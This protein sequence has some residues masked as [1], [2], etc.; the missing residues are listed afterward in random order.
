MKFEVRGGP[1]AGMG[2]ELESEALIIGR[3]PGVQLELQD[4][5][6]S[7]RHAAITRAQDGTVKVE[8][9]ASRNGTKVDGKRISEPTELTGGETIK[10]GQTEIA[11]SA[12]AP[13][14]GATKVAGTPI[15]AG[16]EPDKAEA[17][18]AADGAGAPT[19]AVGAPPPA[20]APTS[21]APAPTEPLPPTKS[22]PPTPPP[23]GAKPPPPPPPPPPPAGKRP[24]GQSRISSLTNRLRPGS[25]R[26]ESAIQ[27]ILLQRSV[28]RA[29]I[30][31]IVAGGVALIAIIGLVL[32]FATDIFDDEPAGEGAQ[33]GIPDE[34]TASDIIEAARP[35]TVAILADVD[36]TNNGGGTGWVLDEEEGLI[37]TN[38]HVIENGETFR[39]MTAE[40]DI[41]PAEVVGVAICD[42]LAVVQVEDTEGMVVLPIGS[43]D[44]LEQGDTVFVLGYPSNLQT[45]PDLQVTEGIVSQVETTADIGPATGDPDLQEYPNVIQTDAAINPGNSGGPMIN[46]DGELIGV[47]T[48]GDESTESQGYAIGQKL[49]SEDLELL[50]EGQSIGWGGFGFAGSGFDL[51]VLFA[52]EGTDA[53]AAGFGSQIPVVLE[54]DGEPTSTREDYCAAVSDVTSG[55]EVDVV[56]ANPGGRP[57]R[58]TLVYP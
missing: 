16:G 4:D 37:V 47:N 6:V 19:E 33:A 38:G 24:A 23:P 3:E 21:Q 36:G 2:A 56:G 39:V 26:S 48:L 8:D 44:E 7:R 51:E 35:S 57:I 25:G 32:F 34:P 52:Q 49:V 20:D 13:G 29:T 11:V 30:L 54:V 50:A 41:Q 28:K 14:R 10:V 45:E 43:Q 12:E 58:G 1:S 55:Q 15:P 17:A 40:G 46:E 31:A 5:E 22:P 42:D 18:E 53:E 9:L 27:R